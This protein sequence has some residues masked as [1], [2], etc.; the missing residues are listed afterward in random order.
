MGC[1]EIRDVIVW[2]L[3]GLGLCTLALVM[4]ALLVDAALSRPRWR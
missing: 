4:L 2:G 1:V 3:A